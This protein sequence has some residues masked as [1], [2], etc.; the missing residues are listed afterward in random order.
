MIKEFMEALV[1]LP[2]YAIFL[3]VFFGIIF[4]VYAFTV[5]ALSAMG[6]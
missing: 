2:L 6:F 4:M 1:V 5:L 3:A